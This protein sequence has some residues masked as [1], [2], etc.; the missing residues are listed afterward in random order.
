MKMITV[1][2]NRNEQE[3]R[4]RIYKT[5]KEAMQNCEP[6]FTTVRAVNTYWTS[7]FIGYINMNDAEADFRMLVK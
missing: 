5:A 7:E 1:P 4:F 6:G 2:I 3:K